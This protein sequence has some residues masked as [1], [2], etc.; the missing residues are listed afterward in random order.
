MGSDARFE[1]LDARQVALVETA[2]KAN[3]YISRAKSDNTRRAYAA[4]WRAFTDW[5]A[6]HRVT[7]LPVE[8]SALALYL[9]DMADKYKVSTIERRLGAINFEHKKAG[10]PAPSTH[11]G[12]RELLQGIRRE[13]GAA[14]TG[15]TPLLTDEI[16]AMVEAVPETPAGD[17]DRAL[18]L[19]GFAGALRRSELAALQRKDIRFT[20]QGMV[21][22]V[23]RSKTDQ[24]GHGAEVGI[25]RGAHPATDPV[26]AVLA[27]IE[28]AKLEDGPL[29]R[30]VD[31][32]GHI[33]VT[34]LSGY[35][36]TIIIQ[37]AAERAGLVVEGSAI[38]AHSLRA[39]HATAAAEAGAEERS[40]M[41]QGR[42]KTERTVRGYIRHGSLFTENSSGKLGI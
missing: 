25:E 11:P 21:V 6:E 16:R 2:R 42:W 34:G 24:D 37:R 13:L 8:P 28:A 1:V 40:I 26:R 7:P 27:W 36:I 35:G 20:P 32:H 29:F 39:G 4:D 38:S 15:Q 22:T 5:C 30:S 14:R 3:G 41:R 33:R 17:R 10:H 19:L 31:K 23:S 18:I 12:V 9:T